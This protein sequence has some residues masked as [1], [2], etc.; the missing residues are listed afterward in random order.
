MKMRPLFEPLSQENKSRY[1][2]ILRYSVETGRD[3]LTMV[4]SMFL[5]PILHLFPSLRHTQWDIFLL[6]GR[7][8]KMRTNFASDPDPRPSPNKTQ[9]HEKLVGSPGLLAGL[10][11]KPSAPIVFPVGT[12]YKC[13]LQVCPLSGQNLWPCLKFHIRHEVYLT[14]SQAS[15]LP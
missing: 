9:C 11:T 15:D 13:S 14:E 3:I 5:D 8:G 6:G 10:I 1:K 7:W 4:E 2:R 12:T